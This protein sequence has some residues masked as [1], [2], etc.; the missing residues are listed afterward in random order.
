[1]SHTDR[2]ELGTNT[3]VQ[4]E[5]LSASSTGAPDVDEGQSQA[6]RW[7]V[8]N[9]EVCTALK[10]IR[11]ADPSFVAVGHGCTALR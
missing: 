6:D 9:D 7:S 11:H 5:A 4:S 1:M 8:L 2:G 3:E 10:R